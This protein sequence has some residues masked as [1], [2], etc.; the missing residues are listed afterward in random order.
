LGNEDR[1]EVI[2]PAKDWRNGRGG[3]PRRILRED[4]AE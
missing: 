1:Y 4:L 2:M 3:G